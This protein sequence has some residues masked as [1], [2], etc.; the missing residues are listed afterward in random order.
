VTTTQAWRA[1]WLAGTRDSARQAAV[2][3]VW[4]VQSSLPASRLRRVVHALA[5]Q[6]CRLQWAER[7]LDGYATGLAQRAV[8]QRCWRQVSAPEVVGSRPAVQS[9]TA[10]RCEGQ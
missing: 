3:Q 5:R 10:H 2:R 6:V 8:V 4:V 1:Q 7:G 9:D